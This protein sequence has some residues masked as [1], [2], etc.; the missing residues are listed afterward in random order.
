MRICLKAL[1]KKKDQRDSTAQD[2][3]QDLQQFLAVKSL[4]S[5]AN[6]VLLSA[7][8]I[9]DTQTPSSDNRRANIVIVP[10]GLRSYEATDSYFF[11][12]LIPGPCDCHGVPEVL[13]FWHSRIVNVENHHSSKRG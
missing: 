12:E 8:I 9:Q 13:R 4:V 1:S 6:P 10:K 7:D 3:A 11:N 2:M 5:I